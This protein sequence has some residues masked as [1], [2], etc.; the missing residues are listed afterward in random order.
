MADLAVLNSEGMLD[1]EFIKQPYGASFGPD[2]SVA[3]IMRVGAGEEVASYTITTTA[4]AGWTGMQ[5][6]PAITGSATG[7]FRVGGTL[8]DA[9]GGICYNRINNASGAMAASSYE[10]EFWVKGH[11]ALHA[12]AYGDSDFKIMIDG[13]HLRQTEF[14]RTLALTGSVYAEVNFPT[15]TEVH[16]VRVFMGQLGFVQ[17]LTPAAGTMWA[18]APRDKV[19][20]TGDSLMHGTGSTSEGG[21]TAA[22]LC[23]LYAIITGKEVWNF[24]EGGSGLQNPGGGSGVSKYG[25]TGRK[26]KYATMT[27]VESIIICGPANDGN[28]STYPVA[29]GRTEMT[30]LTTYLKTTFPDAPIFWFGVE[31]GPYPSIAS[32][33]NT[34][35]AGLKAEAAAH[36]E[37]IARYVDCR[38]DP[39][40]W[41]F[42]T[43]NLSAPDGSGNADLFQ[44]SDIVHPSRK[45]WL[46]ETQRF[47][48]KVRHVLVKK[49]GA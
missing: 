7:R 8:V 38:Q 17:F 42:G 48:S 11:F 23:N 12:F 10:M 18:A 28:I 1:S 30:A 3:P 47:V 13:K 25:S 9:G 15:A 33:L 24:G 39:S 22:T 20:A 37:L 43:G 14:D 32:D 26:A 5:Y 29:T 44:S 35:N 27:D 45:G 34:L 46:Y 21:I 6:W 36:P 31:A 40:L 4:P 16:R 49:K 41:I 19:L 2:G